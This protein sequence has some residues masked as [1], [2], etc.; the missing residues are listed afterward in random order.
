MPFTILRN[1]ITKMKVDAIVNAANTSLQ[2]GGGVCGATFKAAGPEKLQAECAALGGCKTGQ[3]VITSGFK[4]PA[5]YIIHTPG[6]IWKGGQQGEEAL[7]RQCYTNSL[8][9]AE[10]Y[11][12]E[13]I[14]FPLISAGIYGYPKKEALEVAVTAIQD[15]LEHSEMDVFLVVFDKVAVEI[16]EELL[17]AVQAYIDEHYYQEDLLEVSVPQDIMYDKVSEMDPGTS[18]MDTIAGLESLIGNLDEPFSQTLLRLIDAK[19]STDV[20]VYKRANMDRKLFSKIRSNRGY[21]PS[22]KTAVALAIALELNLAEAEDLL[23]RAGYAL[24]SSQIFDVLIRF[25][26]SKGKY[27]MYEINQTLFYFDQP[28]LGS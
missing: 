14:A 11:G 9:L 20:E 4:L 23:A 16:S 19:G 28:L 15:F 8:L 17:G 24:S 27:D 2:K 12:L 18:Q 5:K 10:E 26:I 21:T 6:P 22:K 13:S 3:A 25:F 1:D 7:L